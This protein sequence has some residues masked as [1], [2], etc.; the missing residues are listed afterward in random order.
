MLDDVTWEPY[1]YLGVHPSYP[2]HAAEAPWRRWHVRG[3][4]SAQGNN[5]QRAEKQQNWDYLCNSGISTLIFPKIDTI[6]LQM[7]MYEKRKQRSVQ[8][9]HTCKLMS[10]GLVTVKWLMTAV[11]CVWNHTGETPVHQ[12]PGIPLRTS[13]KVKYI[14]AQRRESF[15][16]KKKKESHSTKWR[17][18]LLKELLIWQECLTFYL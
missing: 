16:K 6:W 11:H 15:T 18:K 4:I 10:T 1:S 9:T 8:H 12:T 13:S 7:N 3:H 14:I 5:Y 17:E 2:W